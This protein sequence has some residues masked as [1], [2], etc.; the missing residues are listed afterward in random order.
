MTFLG[1]YVKRSKTT[2]YVFMKKKPKTHEQKTHKH[3]HWKHWRT[4]RFNVKMK[5]RIKKKK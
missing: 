5:N 3:T 4:K 1:S 2:L